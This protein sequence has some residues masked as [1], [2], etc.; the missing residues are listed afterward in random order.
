M[1]NLSK[2]FVKLMQL[3][4]NKETDLLLFIDVLMLFEQYSME[5]RSFRNYN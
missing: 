4:C 5:S 2:L 3:M 1:Y